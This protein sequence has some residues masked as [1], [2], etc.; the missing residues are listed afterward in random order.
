VLRGCILFGE[1]P[2]IRTVPERVKMKPRG[3]S[4]KGRPNKATAL[5]REAIARFID[6]NADRLQG[7][8]EAIAEEEGPLTAF[9]CYRDLIEY[10]V[11][12]LARTELTGKDGEDLRISWPLPQNPFLDK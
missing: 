3:G 8:L 5:A 2:E 11:P 7:W 1:I 10:H 4:R 12:K 9:N 6:G